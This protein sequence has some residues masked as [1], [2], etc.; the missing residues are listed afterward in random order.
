MLRSIAS[1]AA[2]TALW[3]ILWA[4]TGQSLLA[5]VPDSFNADGGT[6]SAGVLLFLLAISVVLSL[7]AG[8]LTARLAP[9]NAWRHVYWLGALQLAIGLAVQI[10]SW[11]LMPVWY[12]IPFL[13]LLIPG[14]LAGGL[15][16][17]R[18]P[19]SAARA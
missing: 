4:T 13:A 17:L 11:A 8:W 18:G 14:V 2:G 19:L 1:V 15:L 3:G 16:R 6:D 9:K 7:L 5:A 10:G 12:H